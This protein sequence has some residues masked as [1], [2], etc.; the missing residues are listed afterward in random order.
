ML[1]L[2]SWGTVLRAARLTIVGGLGKGLIVGATWPGLGPSYKAVL[3]LK[4]RVKSL[5]LYLFQLFHTGVVVKNV[6]N[7]KI[8]ISFLID[9]FSL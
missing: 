8:F 6:K 5:G 3:G 2:Q 4:E 9:I 1:T 7:S